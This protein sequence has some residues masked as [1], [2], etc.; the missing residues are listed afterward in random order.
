MI[1]IFPVL[2]NTI[3]K[4]FDLLEDLKFLYFNSIDITLAIFLHFKNLL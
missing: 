2:Y 4:I 1:D 3:G